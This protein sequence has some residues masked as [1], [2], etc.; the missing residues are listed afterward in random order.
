M[1]SGPDGFVRDL[2]YVAAWSDE[3]DRSLCN[4]FILGRPVVVFRRRDG[5]VAALEDICPHRWLPLSM[6]RL[7]DD[8]VVE[9]DYHGFRFDPTGRCVGVPSQR[10]VPPLARVRSYPIVERPPLVWI[11][12]G[13]P[14]RAAP[15]RI[16][17]MPELSDAAFRWIVCKVDIDANYLLMH[18]NVMDQTHFHHLHRDFAATPEWD[19][20]Q[21]EVETKNGRVVRR[22]VTLA[23]PAPPV[24]AFAG[25][26]PGSPVDSES[27]GTFVQPGLNTSTTTHRARDSGQIGVLQTFHI[28]S[29]RSPT[30][31]RY[32]IAVGTNFPAANLAKLEAG[33]RNATLEDKTAVEAVQRTR[34]AFAPA[35]EVSVRADRAGLEARRLVREL[36][37]AEAAS[38]EKFRE[39]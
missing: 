8:D 30:R 5:N 15:S 2:W 13:D 21:I 11:Y 27:V 16:P 18:E 10:E 26:E 28:F 22:H 37:Q 19:R 7:H 33:V 31:T 14:E 25:I 39:R 6:G 38:R 29:P 3:I 4:L 20:G 17:E 9:C 32:S 24:A 1:D 35:L 34:T 23:A 36:I 12:A